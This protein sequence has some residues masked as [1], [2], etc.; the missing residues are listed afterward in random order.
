MKCVTPV[1]LPTQSLVPMRLIYNLSLN[2][3]VNYTTLDSYTSFVFL[4]ENKFYWVT[5]LMSVVKYGLIH[6][7]LVLIACVDPGGG[8][9]R[10]SRPPWKITSSMGFYTN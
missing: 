1:F 9:E 3:F 7:I 4:N 6:E 8:G 10:G 2:F 5:I